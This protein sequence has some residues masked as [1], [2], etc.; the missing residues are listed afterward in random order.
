[1]HQEKHL[2][3]DNSAFKPFY[4]SRTHSCLGCTVEESFGQIQGEYSHIIS[5]RLC[6]CR[7]YLTEE[8]ICGILER[9]GMDINS[10]I[11]MFILK[12]HSMPG[13]TVYYIQPAV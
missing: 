1:M 6:D 9:L 11:R 13:S 4:N 8:D 3:I 7:R 10:P 5:L 12:N 2:I